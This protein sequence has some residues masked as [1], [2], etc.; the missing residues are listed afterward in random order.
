MYI[1]DSDAPVKYLYNYGT[2]AADV[3]QKQL[4]VY[5]SNLGAALVETNYFDEER[6]YICDFLT[7]G[8]FVLR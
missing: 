1:N 2:D 7:V 8:L 4:D 5:A 3:A 6:T